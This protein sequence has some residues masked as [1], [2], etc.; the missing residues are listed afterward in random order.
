METG[1]NVNENAVEVQAII[2]Q[3]TAEEN[4]EDEDE[5]ENKNENEMVFF[6]KM[7]DIFI[8]YFEN[9]MI[10]QYHDNRIN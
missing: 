6:M 7:T 10:N 9:E 3:Y 8:F 5:H 4:D 2:S 1:V